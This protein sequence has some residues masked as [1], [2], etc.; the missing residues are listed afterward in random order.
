[1]GF[2]CR[3]ARERKDVL[4]SLFS[5]KYIIASFRPRLAFVF[6]LFI[7]LIPLISR[8]LL[9]YIEKVSFLPLLPASPIS[10]FQVPYPSSTQHRP[11]IPSHHINA[12][13]PELLGDNFDIQLPISQ[14]PRFPCLSY[15]HL[16]LIISESSP[17][18]AVRTSCVPED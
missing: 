3:R 7:L 4:F 10:S 11:I 12:D 17:S 8:P 16:P 15:H 5:C 6:V 13:K 1:M 9:R 2:C 18:Q 14:I